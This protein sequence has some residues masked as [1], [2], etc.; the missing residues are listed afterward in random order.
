M[1]LAEALLDV[2]QGRRV[3]ATLA[4]HPQEMLVRGATPT[5]RRWWT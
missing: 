2:L 1:L 3:L 5:T 4:A